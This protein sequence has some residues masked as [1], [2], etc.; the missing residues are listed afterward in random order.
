[1]IC[2]PGDELL[3]DHSGR[4]QNAHI[5][6]RRHKREMLLVLRDEREVLAP[7]RDRPGREFDQGE[8]DGGREQDGGSQNGPPGSSLRLPVSF[9]P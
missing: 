8:A 4:A 6:F 3:P 7:G 9:K 1:M 2:E 5:D